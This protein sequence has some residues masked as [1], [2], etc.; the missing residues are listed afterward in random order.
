[1][2]QSV[3]LLACATLRFTAAYLALE[4]LFANVSAPI[5]A[6]MRLLIFYSPKPSTHLITIS[7]C[8]PLNEAILIMNILLD[9][10]GFLA[11]SIAIAN[12]C[13]VYTSSQKEQQNKLFE[14]LKETRHAVTDLQESLDDE[15]IQI[16]NLV[17][18]AMVVEVS[19]RLREVT[20][21]PRPKLELLIKILFYIKE[22]APNVVFAVIVKYH[23]IRDVATLGF[24]GT[25]HDAIEEQVRKIESF[26]RSVREVKKEKTVFINVR[27]RG[28]YETYIENFCAA[29]LTLI[30]IAVCD[31]KGDICL[32]NALDC[33]IN[34]CGEKIVGLLQPEGF[35]SDRKEFDKLSR[36]YLVGDT[37]SGK[38]TLGNALVGKGAF[39]VSK[40]MTGT[41][42]IERGE[43]VEDVA[44]KVWVSEIY[45]T[46]GLNDKDGLDIFY[47]CAIE[48]HI[49]VVQRVSSLIMTV[50]VDSG[51]SHSPFKSLGTYKE[52]FGENMTSMLI[53]VLTIND[54][55]EESELDEVRQLN[56][57]T[58]HGLDGR[59]K[60]RNVFCLSLHDL[61]NDGD[62]A[63]H[64]VVGEIAEISR[65]MPLQMIQTLAERY[66]KLRDALKA[67]SDHV[68]KQVAEIMNDGWQIYDDLTDQ[69][70]SSPYVK[71]TDDNDGFMN[72]FVM[73]KTGHRKMLTA[74]C[75]LGIL[76]CIRKT[77]VHVMCQGKDAEC[78]WKSFLE[79]NSHQRQN[80]E[81]MRA[82]G[83][84]LYDWG[85]GVIVKDMDT[86]LVGTLRVKRYKVTI[87]NPFSTAH[88]ELSPCL[89]DLISGS[90]EELR[91]ELLRELVQSVLPPVVLGGCTKAKKRRG[92]Q[93][94]GPGSSANSVISPSP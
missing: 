54:P 86:T 52:L 10:V 29:S 43:R 66:R 42:R 25:S 24:A 56:W 57:P 7:P 58:I 19:S 16:R 41:M 91:P 13:G 68:D 80:R 55:A 47:Q 44:N 87:V 27:I 40:R 77:A 73:K 22:R 17:S 61:R 12:A 51:M 5:Y 81:V 94:N 45:D 1:M 28:K 33:S 21:I 67:K 63:S 18:T 84:Y 30:A 32:D 11:D 62:S 76:N 34:P 36:I 83:D 85:L 89:H 53:V 70:E 78:A 39:T 37:R 38:S 14:A 20:A 9:P 26:C 82:F 35:G 88:D 79:N 65:G 64:A 60:E 48:D 69:F 49:K 92:G 59:I 74:F 72:G 93:R 2:R 23:V 71:L 15:V 31:L 8:Q 6:Y 75:T 4:Q 3:N 50:N 46:P 90:A